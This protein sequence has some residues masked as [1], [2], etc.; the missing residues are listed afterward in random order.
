MVYL[1]IFLKNSKVSI[2]QSVFN[3]EMAECIS[4]QVQIQ[5]INVEYV[6]LLQTSSVTVMEIS[7]QGSRQW[8][9]VKA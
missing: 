4:I 9:K 5:C 1:F 8:V 3:K 7:C 2:N 6:V